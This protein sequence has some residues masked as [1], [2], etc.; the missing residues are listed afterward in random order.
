MYILIPKSA[1]TNDID[2]IN[3][4][5]NDAIIKINNN[6][7]F[8]YVLLANFFNVIVSTNRIAIY[9]IKYIPY[10]YILVSP[11]MHRYDI[12]I[13]DI[14]I[15]YIFTALSIFL[16]SLSIPAIKIIYVKYKT[17]KQKLIIF[18]EFKFSN[19]NPIKYA[20]IINNNPDKVSNIK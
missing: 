9:K 13:I 15:P 6:I 10:L 12:Y 19:F 7:P 17:T 14:A 2:V 8:K 4:P 1:V 16:F 11:T 3:S 5:V 20:I 18:I